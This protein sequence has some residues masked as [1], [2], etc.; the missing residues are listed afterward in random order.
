[1]LVSV[2]NTVYAPLRPCEPPSA[3][4]P[5]LGA[6]PTTVPVAAIVNTVLV[7]LALL[8]AKR[9]GCGRSSNT[10]NSKRRVHMRDAD[11]GAVASAPSGTPARQGVIGSAPVQQY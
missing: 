2:C 8:L 10:S 11:S 1:M 7:G 4:D 5:S 3:Q 9:C 6:P